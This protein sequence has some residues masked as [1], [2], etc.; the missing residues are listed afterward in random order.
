MTQAML[1]ANWQILNSSLPQ[2]LEELK[3][4][5]LSNRHLNESKRFFSP[6][7]PLSFKP[8]EL[9][10]DGKEIKKMCARLGRAHKN[11]E[12]IVIFGDYDADGICATSILWRLLHDAGFNVLPF[13]P[14]R[15]EHGYGLSVKAATE[16]MAQFNPALVLSVDNGVVAH[17]AVSWLKQKTVDVIITDHHQ[18]EKDKQ[19]KVVWPQALAVILSIKLCGASM[20][21]MV[22]KLILEFLHQSSIENTREKL[23]QELDLC[24]L[25]TI[26]D[27]VPLLE[28]NRSFAHFGLNQL[29]KTHR[30]GLL[31][32]FAQAKIT[33]ES[34]NESSIGYTL[35]PRINALG[36][37]AE[38]IVGVRLLCTK[39]PQLAEVLASKLNEL[40]TA[41]QEVT[42]AAMDQAEQQVTKQTSAHIITVYSPLFHEGVIGLV[43]GK[44]CEKYFKPAFVMSGD[45]EII[46][47]SARGVEGLNITELLRKLKSKLIDVGGH[48]LA[49]GFSLK[50]NKFAEFETE[51]HA[52]AKT[53]IDPKLLEEKM[54][55]DCVLP[56][57]LVNLETA[58]MMQDFAPFGQANFEP[59]FMISAAT[60]VT[61]QAM[62]K[63]SQHLKLSLELES[64]NSTNKRNLVT[65]IYWRNGQR[66]NDLQV[67]QKLDLLVGLEINNWRG[68]E[69]LQLAVLSLGEV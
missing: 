50:K 27:Q 53:E 61:C 17:E 38:G 3:N 24:A 60:L 6:D 7:H 21:W 59:S 12:K 23:I 44:L 36:R 57:F 48:P 47:G 65:A 41:R 9:G 62:G 11:Q 37:M 30:P 13:I 42:K 15:Q 10:I 1:K 32:L 5:L 2:S 4:I 40:N 68:H 29:K 43:A 63:E 26:A 49:A 25:A 46:K 28:A 69:A 55:L 67:G 64:K 45:G 35:A 56:H 19:S 54:T 39:K 16:M 34:I 52:L 22:G 14:N 33:K 58:K 51:L 8:K 31:A 20:A 18:P 66:A